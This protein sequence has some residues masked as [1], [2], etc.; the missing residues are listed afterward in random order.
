MMEIRDRKNGASK[1]LLRS[2]LATALLAGGAAAGYAAARATEVPPP[3]SVAHA[4]IQPG[5]ATLVATV[6]PAVVNISTTETAGPGLAGNTPMDQMLKQFFGPGAEQRLEQTQRSTHALG[7]GF[8]IDPTGYIV[9]NNHVIDD[10]TDIQVTLTDGS[11]HAARIVGRDQ[12]TDLALLRI[13]TSH[14]LPYVAFG[15]SSKAQVG[16]W[17]VA[18]GNPYGLGGSVSAGVVSARNRNIDEGPYDDFLQIDAPINPGNSGGPLFDQS[19]HVIGIDTAIYTPSGGSVGI[20]FAIPSNVVQRVVAQLREHGHVT[21][22]WL[23]VQ[24]Q[25][26]TPALATATGLSKTKGVLVDLVTPDSPA[27]RAHIQQGD[28]IT[29]FNGAPISNMRDL[30]FAV[31]DTPAGKTVPISVWRSGHETTLN[32]TIGSEQAQHLAS[33][34]GPSGQ[35]PTGLE[36]API[37]SDEREQLNITGGAM[38]AAVTPG[39]DADRSGLQSGDIILGIGAHKVASPGDAAAQ[40]RAARADH[41]SSLALLVMRNGTE[42]YIPLQLGT[43]SG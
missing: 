43:A 20:G 18:I 14:P 32:V 16:D 29:A 10:A 42:S 17:V 34:T 22:G 35:S 28:V 38:V 13:E 4:Q 1:S 9:T 21:R 37:P 11:V 25:A 36:L 15:D 6:K 7:S 3:L 39:G 41:R 12:K 26:V 23:G 30:A 19:G 24:M 27:A 2:L 31:A 33:A 5:F 40:I 8:I